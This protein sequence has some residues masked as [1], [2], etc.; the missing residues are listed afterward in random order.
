MN[1]KIRVALVDGGSHADLDNKMSGLRY[2]MNQNSTKSLVDVHVAKV[3]DIGQLVPSVLRDPT[4]GFIL[5]FLEFELE[6]FQIRG[7]FPRILW[8]ED[9]HRYCREPLYSPKR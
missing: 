3:E 7:F 1:D 9:S 6:V 4:D 8:N 2:A 5:A